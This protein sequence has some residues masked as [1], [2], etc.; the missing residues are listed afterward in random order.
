MEK[1]C[2]IGFDFRLALTHEAHPGKQIG[3]HASPMEFATL[4][5]NRLSDLGGSEPDDQ[6]QQ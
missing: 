2:Q 5:D 3:R 4:P 6:W 1:M